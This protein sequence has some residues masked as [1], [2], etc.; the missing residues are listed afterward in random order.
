MAMAE[1]PAL[2]GLSA[3]FRDPGPEA[4]MADFKL[5]SRSQRPHALRIPISI[6]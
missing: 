3:R 4:M 2:P 5:P 1:I 6:C